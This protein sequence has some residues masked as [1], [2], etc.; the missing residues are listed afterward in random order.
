[1]SH[2]LTGDTLGAQDA[3]ACLHAI[4]YALLRGSPSRRSA[5][6]LRSTSLV[7]P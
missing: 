4:P 3:L 2:V 6:M 5:T 1:M 7:P